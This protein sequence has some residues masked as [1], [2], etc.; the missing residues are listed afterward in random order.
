MGA[1]LRYLGKEL[2]QVPAKHKLLMVLSDGK[3]EDQGSYYGKY[4]VEDT[5]HAL[6][7]LRHGGIHAFCVTLDKAGGDYLPFMIGAA[8]YL[9]IDDVSQLPQRVADIY[10]RLTS[11]RSEKPA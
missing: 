5:R 10:R 8:N 2:R 3:P 9:R 7:E 4:G 6:L 1:A 11:R